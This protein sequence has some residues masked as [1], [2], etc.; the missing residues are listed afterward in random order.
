MEDSNQNV[1]QAPVAWVKATLRR[2]VDEIVD[3][4]LFDQPLIEAKPFWIFP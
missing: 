3:I 2:A 4:G 1:G